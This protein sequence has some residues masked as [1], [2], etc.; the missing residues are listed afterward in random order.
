MIVYTHDK[1]IDEVKSKRIKKGGGGI[2]LKRDG[3]GAACTLCRRAP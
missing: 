1:E 3:K 2:S